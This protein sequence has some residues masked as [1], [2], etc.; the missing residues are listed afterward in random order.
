M[1]N[2]TEANARKRSCYVFN[3]SGSPK[4][5]GEY[6]PVSKMTKLDDPNTINARYLNRK[7]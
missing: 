2:V 4:P 7:T 6:V 3:G 1:I 5:I